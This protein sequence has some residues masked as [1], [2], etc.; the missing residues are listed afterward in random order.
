MQAIALKWMSS[1]GEKRIRTLRQFP[2]YFYID[3]V[4]ILLQASL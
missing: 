1:F 4:N 2:F 3:G